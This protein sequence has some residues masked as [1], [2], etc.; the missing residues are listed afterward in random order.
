M[1]SA[2]KLTAEQVLEAY[3]LF[4]GRPPE[5]DEAVAAAIAAHRDVASYWRTLATSDEFTAIRDAGLNPQVAVLCAMR[6][7]LWA[8][9][10]EIQHS[11]DAGTLARLMERVRQQ[12]VALGEIDPRWSVLTND[13][14]RKENMDAAALARFE[15]SGLVDASAIAQLERLAG[16]DAGSGD[17][18]ELGC[19]V[20]RVT[21]HLARR[22]RKVYAVDVSPGNLRVCSDYMHQEGVENVEVVQ[23]E[24]LADFETLPEIDFFYSI[25]VLQHNSPPIQ[26]LMLGQIL[27]RIRPGGGAFFQ[28]PNYIPG[29]SFDP[30]AYLASDSPEMEMHALPKPVVLKIIRD[31]GMEI[32]DVVP[33][34]YIGQFGSNTFLAVKP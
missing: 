31:A 32:I 10:A 8:A 6:D 24:S 5:S 22:F 13:D 23:V 12:W 19:G 25:I 30:E 29:Y 7:A 11:V 28:I 20:G 16:V 4:L 1:L 17:C 9:P 26:K 2:H 14:F 3:L 34:G 33:D 18:L 27:S 15:N 21:R